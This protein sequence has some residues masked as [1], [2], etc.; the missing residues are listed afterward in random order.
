MMKGMRADDDQSKQIYFRADRVTRIN[1][2]YFFATREGTL[3]GPYETQLQACQAIEVYI[4]R[5]IRLK[6]APKVPALPSSFSVP[7][8][9]CDL[10]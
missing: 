9:L 8:S 10:H 4:M 7:L 1:G 2:Q 6:N 5:M 3:E